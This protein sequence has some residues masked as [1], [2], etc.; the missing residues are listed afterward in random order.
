MVS[1]HHACAAVVDAIEDIDA[2][3]LRIIHQHVLSYRVHL[4]GV[5]KTTKLEFVWTLV[6][7]D[8]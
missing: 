8:I 2:H 1:P 7:L 6:G 3:P 5:S 4:Q